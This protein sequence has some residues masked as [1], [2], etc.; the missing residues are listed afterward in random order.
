MFIE[1]WSCHIFQGIVYWKPYWWISKL[2]FLSQS[3]NNVAK[4]CEPHLLRIHVQEMWDV[5]P[6]GY[7]RLW[8]IHTLPRIHSF[9]SLGT[10][11]EN[12]STKVP[13]KFKFFMW[14]MIQKRYWTADRL[15]RRNLP[16]PAAC[17]LCDQ[18]EETIDHMLT[19]CVFARQFWFLF[20]HHFNLQELLPTNEDESFASLRQRGS[21][22]VGVEIQKGF[23]PVVILGS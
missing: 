16:H 17:L 6:Q 13:N 20:L 23:D 2:P 22:R 5:K 3:R 7:V 18:Q 9:W 12:L 14:L 8:T 1:V 10:Y 11:L 21:R 19:S 15:A 4:W